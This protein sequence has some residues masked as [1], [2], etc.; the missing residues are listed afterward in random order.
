MFI[1]E[2]GSVDGP[3]LCEFCEVTKIIC[4]NEG[5]RVA[6]NILPKS[7]RIYA[8]SHYPLLQNL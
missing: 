2:N 1:G 7:V 6:Y 4:E 8:N 3:F 5:K